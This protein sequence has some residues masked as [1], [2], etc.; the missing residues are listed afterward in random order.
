MPTTFEDKTPRA[1]EPQL[2]YLPKL[3]LVSKP[4]V[5]L[6]GPGVPESQ[7]FDSKQSSLHLVELTSGALVVLDMYRLVYFTAD[8][9]FLRTV[10]RRGQGPGEFSQT[11]SICA[12][13][14]DTVVVKDIAGRATYW[15][16]EGQHF[17]TVPRASYSPPGSCDPHG[18]LVVAQVPTSQTSRDSGPR[19]EQKFWYRVVN[20]VGV[21]TRDLGLLPMPVPGVA[22]LS[23]SLLLFD[24]GFI[25][26]NGRT[27][28]FRR[29]DDSGRLIRITRLLRDRDAI[30]DAQWR[31][32]I[33]QSIPRDAT[34]FDSIN[35]R[36]SWAKRTRPDRYPAYS[37][38]RADTDGRTWV[39]DYASYSGWTIFDTSGLLIGRFDNY[40]QLS[41]IGRNFIAL[42]V[43]DGDGALTVQLF[44]IKSDPR[45][46]P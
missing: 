44:K 36:G 38:M 10:G 45:R 3:E 11:V 22:P 16:S 23:P 20:A 24:R 31:K 26:G 39:S 32:A 6:G 8:G 15:G 34:S 28:E 19:N 37:Y 4:F 41:G 29:Y 25:F 40:S 17:R 13:S 33:E 5:V 2:S 43:R 14:G 46:G 42:K 21:T 9:K 7:E 27:F 12:T 35:I 1:T 18:G 30:T